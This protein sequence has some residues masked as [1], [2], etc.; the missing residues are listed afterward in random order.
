MTNAA[1]RPAPAL[2][3]IAPKRVKGYGVLRIPNV[4]QECAFMRVMAQVIVDRS[5]K[6][7]NYKWHQPRTYYGTAQI[8]INAAIS[9]SIELH[10]GINEVIYYD[11]QAATLLAYNHCATENI[12]KTSF[13]FYSNLKGFLD[14]IGI[15]QI[16]PTVGIIPIQ[17][18]WLPRV[19]ID[20]VWFRTDADCAIAVWAEWM[21]LD[22][23]CESA[24]GNWQPRENDRGQKPSGMPNP[25]GQGDGGNPQPGD[26]NWRPADAPNDSDGQG[27]DNP[28]VGQPAPPGKKWWIG[29]TAPWYDGVTF[30]ED[31]QWGPFSARP[32][33]SLGENRNSASD[34]FSMPLFI[35]G[36]QVTLMESVGSPP[37]LRVGLFP[38]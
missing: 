33:Y 32:S 9:Q 27:G 29:F 5:S 12:N 11:N 30:N 8:V 15:G 10:Y 24:V 17:P 13:A 1:R 21:P 7:E 16:V 38:G 19:P 34:R 2:A 23:S 36:A 35:N 26:P 3:A 18:P 4:A 22:F 14:T 20:E 6:S 28:F 37:T 25:S 31:K